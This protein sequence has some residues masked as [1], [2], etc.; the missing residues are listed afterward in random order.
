MQERE[1]DV[2]I[3]K[4]FG[5]NSSVTNLLTRKIPDLGLKRMNSN[6]APAKVVLFNPNVSRSY[7]ILII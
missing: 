1:S 3:L 7:Y 6:P 2:H 4:L 5:Y